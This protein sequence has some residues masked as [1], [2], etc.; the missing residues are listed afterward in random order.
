MAIVDTFFDTIALME[1]ASGVDLNGLRDDLC[2]ARDLFSEVLGVTAT[3]DQRSKATGAPWHKRHRLHVLLDATERIVKTQTVLMQDL[4][5]ATEMV[6]TVRAVEKWRNDEGWKNI[7]NGFINEYKHT[8]HLLHI[9]NYLQMEG[10]SPKFVQTGEHPTPDLIFWTLDKNYPVYV[11]IYQP[12]IFQGNALRIPLSKTAKTIKKAVSKAKRQLG[13]KRIGMVAICG[14]NQRQEYLASLAK[15]AEAEMRRQT[16]PSFAGFI[17]AN[18]GAEL[19]ATQ[20]AI[21]SSPTF[22][23][24]VCLNELYFGP[25][26]FKIAP[27]TRSVSVNE[28]ISLLLASENDSSNFPIIHPNGE[29]V[30]PFF[31]G[32]GNVDF[33]CTNCSATLIKSAWKASIHKIVIECPECK[34]L[35][36]ATAVEAELA[37]KIVL[38]GKH[39]F[40]S[41]PAFLKLGISL[42]GED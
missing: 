29:G 39:F 28:R 34:T 37:N 13:A 41:G 2:R 25:V 11:E 38:K 18:V 10:Y 22:S 9:A 3:S 16:L 4:I 26:T 5:F 24:E 12:S 7:Q 19:T 35:N 21:V 30:P 36:L 15:A 32:K 33:L 17:I 14:F 23:V 27:E 1:E 6:S 20:N 8:V 42:L 40:F 31:V